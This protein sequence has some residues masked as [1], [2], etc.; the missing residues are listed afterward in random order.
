M[1]R[2]THTL[3]WGYPQRGL[4][5]PAGQLGWP[6][7]WAR[8]E[9][10]APLWITPAALWHAPTRDTACPPRV[11]GKG[12]RRGKHLSHAVGGT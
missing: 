9:R 6:G 3:G 5:A 8:R 11:T 1:G 10:N 2:Y 4:G 7:S 12:R